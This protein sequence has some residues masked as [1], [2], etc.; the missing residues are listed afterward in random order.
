MRVLVTGA[1]GFI[2]RAVLARLRAEGHEP[3]PLSRGDGRGG[4]RSAWWQPEQGTIDLS[5][6]GRIDGAVH[7]AG[8]SVLGRWTAAKRA[9]IRD[10]RVQGTPLLARAL[11]ALSPPPSVLVSASAIGYYGD[12]GQEPVREDS[13]PG[14]GFLAEVCQAWEAGTAP[15]AQAGIR[16]VLPRIGMVLSPT[17]KALRMMLP[18]FR[19]GLGGVLGSGRQYMPWITLEDV[20]GVI[21]QALANHA[22]RGPI[23][24]VAPEA[25]TNRQF[26]KTLGRVV[27]RPTI[28]PVPASALRL[29]LGQM[30][31]EMLLAGANA[32][33]ARLQSLGYPFRHPALEPALRELLAAPSRG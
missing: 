17:G 24:A 15:A 5:G 19:L 23:N 13:P 4:A 6:A 26:T 30:A 8:E 21:T 2:G 9:R 7:L 22:Y 32:Q 33:P 31:D 11:A 27:G 10:S 14:Q 12:R 16:V 3:V 20:T 1:S 28:L 25:V 29:V 18:A